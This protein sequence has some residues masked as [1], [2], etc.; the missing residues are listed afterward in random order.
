MRKIK[1]ILSLMLCS[2]LLLTGC[3][4]KPP[5]KTVAHNI[6]IRL[7]AMSADEK[8][9]NV[10]RDQ[11]TKAGYAVTLNMQP[12]YSSY[13]GQQDAGNY[14]IIVT[15]WNTVSGNP[16]YAVRSL[17]KTGGDYNNSPIADAEID[18]LVEM[19]ATQTPE[20]YKKT[21]TDFEKK[22]VD[23]HAYIAPLFTDI[24]SQAFN[25]TIL[26][27]ESVR[28]SKSRSMAWEEM[29]FIDESKRDTQAFIT[30][31]PISSLT[32]LD[33]IKGN[34]GSINILNT[35]TD[36]RLVNLTDDDQITSKG[37]LSYEHAIADGNQEYYFI[38]RDDVNFVKVD[39]NK[40]PYDSKELVGAEDVVFS[41]SRAMDKNSVPDH[42]T[43]SLH[44]SMEKAEIITDLST[45]DNV[46]ISGTDQSVKAG[47][48]ASLAVPIKELV[49]DKTKVNNAEGSYQV[50]KVTTKSQFPQVLNYLAHQS[51]GIVSEKQ[52]KAVNTYDVATY[53]RNK[54]VAYG[55]QVSVTEGSAYN[56]V[57]AA[58]GPYVLTYKNDYEAIFEKNPA[59]MVGTEFEPKIQTVKLKFI[60]DADSSLSA[61]RSGEIHLLYGVPENKFDIIEQDANLTLMQILSN[62]IGYLGFNM[63]PE[64]VC[65][66]EL[67]RKSILYAI[68]QEELCA[69]Y[70]NKKYPAY[71]TVSPLV[72]TGNKLVY[73]AGK[74]EQLAEEYLNSIK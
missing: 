60:A 49:A 62:R 29:D 22:L 24:R 32:S 30:S 23:E 63:K 34:D 55:D 2:A 11:L 65:T 73:E 28:L 45:L 14:D 57:L 31:Q 38:L 64:A 52:V 10:V 43:Y 36:I 17:F 20:E 41:L 50:V 3:T 9:A 61:L 72:E 48:E 51:A 74:S 19:A 42:R 16:D 35:N 12:D 47:L 6:P 53:D 37:S 58:S 1:R 15:S 25:K 4:T 69:V 27:E 70:E 46:K 39:E 44:E 13:A 68:N 67:L 66:N 18:E 40:K 8:T 33:P 56:N 71:S 26:K 7:L 59:Y 5:V 54:D 21:Y